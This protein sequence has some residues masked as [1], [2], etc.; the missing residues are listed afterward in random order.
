MTRRSREVG[1]IKSFVLGAALAAAL[2]VPAQA[3]DNKLALSAT[4]VFTT[5]Y[6]FRGYSN[7][8]NGPAVQPEFDLTYGIFYAGIWGSNIKPAAGTNVF[9]GA[10]ENIG[11]IEID[12]YAGI[13]PKWKEITFNIGALYYTYPGY[14]E[15]KCG[16][17]DPDYFELKTGAAYTFGQKLTLGVVNYWS[18]DYFGFAGNS[19]ALE[20]SAA[21]A[22]AGKLFNFFSPTISGGVGYQWFEDVAEDYAYWNAGLTLGFME[23]WS[24]DVRYWDTDLSD[25]GCFTLSTYPGGSECD[26]RVVGSLKAVF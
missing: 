13:T 19:D 4:T 7:T 23:H 12:Y 9:T 18:D 5:D 17:L 1:I 14:C 24:V 8:G 22:F 21:Y 10:P 25:A 2:A 3:G 16:L 20:G 6:I 11:D 26:A 15:G